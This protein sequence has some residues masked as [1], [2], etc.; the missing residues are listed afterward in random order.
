MRWHLPSLTTASVWQ[1]PSS[2]QAAPAL[3]DAL[4][5]L[6]DDRLQLR[7]LNDDSKPGRH[8]GGT[9]SEGLTTRQVNAAAVFLCRD[10]QGGFQARIALIPHQDLR[11]HVTEDFVAI[12]SAVNDEVPGRIDLG[13][14]AARGERWKNGPGRILIL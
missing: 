4:P 8:A 5:L 14:Q 6:T 11:P 2:P 10:A 9:L 13:S 7:V 12:G 3:P 1:C